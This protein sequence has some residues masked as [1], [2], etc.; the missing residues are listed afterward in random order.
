MTERTVQDVFDEERKNETLIEE[1]E[2]EIENI[3][4]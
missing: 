4:K 1:L 3:K 2:E